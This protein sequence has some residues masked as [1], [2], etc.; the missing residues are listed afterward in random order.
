[1]ECHSCQKLYWRGT[2]W[3]NM[4]QELARVGEGQP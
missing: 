3:H 4:L 1:M 2:H